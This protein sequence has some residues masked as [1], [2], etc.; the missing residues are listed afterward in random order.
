MNPQAPRLAKTLSRV[1]TTIKAECMCAGHALRGVSR[2]DV[3]IQGVLHYNTQL[4]SSNRLILEQRWQVCAVLNQQF[5]AQRQPF[6]DPTFTKHL[7]TGLLCRYLPWSMIV[8]YDNW[9][10]IKKRLGNGE[11]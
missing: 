6:P 8:G 10:T 5:E 4:R 3:T 1:T 2:L 9:Q 7:Q 11:V